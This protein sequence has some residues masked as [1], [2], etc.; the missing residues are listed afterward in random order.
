ME[1][2]TFNANN[3]PIEVLRGYYRGDKYVFEVEVGGYHIKG[4]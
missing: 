4:Q 1:S 2:V 3:I